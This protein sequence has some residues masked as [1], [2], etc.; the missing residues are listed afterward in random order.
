MPPAAALA[1]LDLHRLL[2]GCRRRGP[3]LLSCCIRARSPG[4]VS[5]AGASTSGWSHG[6]AGAVHQP[7]SSSASNGKRCGHLVPNGSWAGL[8]V[9]L[10]GVLGQILFHATGLGVMSELSILVVLFGAVLFIF[11]W[12]HLEDS[13]VKPIAFLAYCLAA[14]ATDVRSDDVA[15]ASASW[16]RIWVCN[17]CPSFMGQGTVQG[18]YHRR[19]LWWQASSQGRWRWRMRAAG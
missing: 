15:F 12:E 13:L 17:C 18:N 10:L 16:R 7:V 1:P 2:D 14:A 8:W 19:L 11:G 6:S 3:A 4:V 5:H 9:L